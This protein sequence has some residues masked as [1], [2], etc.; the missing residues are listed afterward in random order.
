MTEAKKLRGPEEI[1]DLDAA[2]AEILARL[3]EEAPF[4]GWSV[5]AL[6][7][8]ASAAGVTREVQRL[9]FPKGIGDALALYSRQADEAAAARLAGAD[10]A[11]LR[12]RERVA[13][14]VRARIEVLAPHKDAA[15]LAA[16]TLSL[17]FH[18][19]LAAECVWRTVDMLWR[20]AGDR[21][22]DFNYYTKR[23]ILSAVYGTTLLRWFEDGSEGCEESWAFLAA[24]IENVMTFEK[25]KAGARR[26]AAGLPSP[27]RL[28]GALRY[29]RD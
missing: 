18:A 26:A 17:P 20:A 14:A 3:L 15:R 11:R 2:R 19:P 21:S 1:A 23:A 12:I 28:L 9:A 6:R 7:R 22:T 24:R 4:H 13:A 16:R 27:W 25:A 29:P 8:A 5:P 10:L